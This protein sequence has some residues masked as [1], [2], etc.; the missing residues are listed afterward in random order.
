MP[1]TNNNNNNSNNISGWDYSTRLK[2]DFKVLLRFFFHQLCQSIWRVL[3][4]DFKS[5]K[6]KSKEFKILTWCILFF[7]TLFLREIRQAVNCFPWHILVFYSLLYAWVGIKNEKVVLSLAPTGVFVS[8]LNSSCPTFPHFLLHSV[9]PQQIYGACF[10]QTWSLVTTQSCWLL[11]KKERRKK[12][13]KCMVAFSLQLNKCLFNLAEKIVS[14]NFLIDV[15][16]TWSP[17]S[18]A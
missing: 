18:A 16:K 3:R 6:G 9:A 7:F 13:D 17:K 14:V 8:I 1:G 15:N 4:L 11:W 2:Y 5:C 12:G 10:V